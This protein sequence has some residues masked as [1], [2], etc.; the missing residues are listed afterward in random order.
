MCAYS[1][2]L[3]YP[4]FAVCLINGYQLKVTDSSEK[5]SPIRQGLLAA[6]WLL[7]AGVWLL[8]TDSLLHARSKKREA[9]SK[10][11]TTK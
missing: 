9:G 2:L 4:I 3:R 11:S 7:A 1:S 8:A 5:I 10:K 6:H